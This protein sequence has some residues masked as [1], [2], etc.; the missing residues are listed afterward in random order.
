MPIPYFGRIQFAWCSH[1][2]VPLILTKKCSICG[3]KADQIPLTPPGEVR[4][5]FPEMVSSFRNT[6]DEIY[7]HGTGILILPE[8]K[9]CHGIG[10]GHMQSCRPTER[11]K[12][13]Q[14]SNAGPG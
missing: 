3:T 10:A 14:G 1:C 4:P 13:R 8:K 9:L 7:G 12:T 5:L 6:V 11:T 2:N